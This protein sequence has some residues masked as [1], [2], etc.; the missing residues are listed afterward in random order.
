MGNKLDCHIKDI[1]DFLQNIRI[2]VYVTPENYWLL[3]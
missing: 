2:N 3:K 1:A